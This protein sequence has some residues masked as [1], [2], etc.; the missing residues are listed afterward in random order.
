MSEEPI[1]FFDG[2]CNLCNQAVQVVIKNDPKKN[3]HFAPLQGKKGTALLQDPRLKEGLPDSF[4]LRKNGQL[5]FRSRA[6]LETARYLKFPFPLLYG[7]IIVPPFIRDAVYNWIA[8][9]RY[10]WFGKKNECMVPS[11]ELKKR[12]YD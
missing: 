4:I 7:F 5:F 6:A 11:P 8:R 9:N 10:R 3:F 1:I 12:F 2:V